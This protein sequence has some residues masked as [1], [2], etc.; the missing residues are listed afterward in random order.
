MDKSDKKKSIIFKNIV[1]RKSF[2]I[3]VHQD[4]LVTA[5]EDKHKLAPIHILIIP[6]NYIESMNYV[7]F[8]NKLLLGHMFYTATKLAK[9][10]NIS[11]NGYRLIVNCNEN[12]GQEIP[13]LHI[14]LLGGKKL[15]K[16]FC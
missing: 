16:H 13:Y 9:K 12:G 3:I 5:F 6:N 1:L 8:E 14:H 15:S 11:E 2:A 10:F 4:E 7:T